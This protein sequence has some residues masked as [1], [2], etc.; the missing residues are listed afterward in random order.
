M[1][2]ARLLSL[3]VLTSFLTISVIGFPDRSTAQEAAKEAAKDSGDAP[4]GEAKA[5]DTA[6]AP[7][8]L[9]VYAEGLDDSAS[10]WAEY[11]SSQGEKVEVLAWASLWPKQEGSAENA[12][13]EAGKEAGSSEGSK[14]GAYPQDETPP[15]DKPPGDKPAGDKPAEEKPAGE[16]PAGDTPAE[17]EAESK[18]APAPAPAAA[19]EEKDHGPQ[20]MKDLR[21]HIEKL[22]PKSDGASERYVLILGDVPD[23]SGDGLGRASRSRIP[24]Y[25]PKGLTD[26]VGQPVFGDYKLVATGDAGDCLACVGR[27]PVHTDEV[28]LA[29][30]E[31]IKRYE[32]AEAGPWQ[33]N[34]NF[35]AGEGGFVMNGQS[36]DRMLESMFSQ[37]ADEQI[38]PTFA[39][40]MT[41]A[42]RDSPWCP[43]PVELEDRV[44]SSFTTPS[45]LTTYIGHANFRKFGEFRIRHPQDSS[46]VKS[47]T[48]FNADSIAKIPT[49]VPEG[50]IPGMMLVIACQAGGIDQTEACLS[51]LLVTHPCGPVAMIASSRDSHPYANAIFQKAVIDGVT[52]GSGTLGAVHA[53]ARRYLLDKDDAYRQQIDMMAA[54]F[55]MKEEQMVAMA[56]SHLHIYNLIGDP[57]LRIRRQQSLKLEAPG[58]SKPGAKLKIDFPDGQPMLP[59][60]KGEMKV[61]PRGSAWVTLELLPSKFRNEQLPPN[62]DLLYGDDDYGYKALMKRLS[63]NH[64]VANDKQV[65]RPEQ[66]NLNARSKH[67]YFEIPERVDAGSYRVQVAIQPGVAGK[68][69]EESKAS[70]FGSLALRVNEE[71]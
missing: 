19:K 2:A 70:W 24:W 66:L 48:Y 34:L 67:V 17:G 13:E 47:Y 54:M 65:T 40:N 16:K 27:I 37:Y 52:K 45:L 50:H 9:I 69:A 62:W 10:A 39:V 57:G 71:K 20:A 61:P 14:P 11:R 30:L 58:S 32:A 44:V 49:E 56:T 53:N 64:R 22:W 31:K 59:N 23:A 63:D 60:N 33:R 51:E 35:F 12:S 36:V 1:R 41:Y 4:A 55:Q 46:K 26:A 68:Q 5:D 3:G 25:T 28:G 43:P 15:G 42:L 7:T 38:P 6:K 21:A 18:E 29:V 8:A